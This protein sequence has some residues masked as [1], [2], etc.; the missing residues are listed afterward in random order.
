MSARRDANSAASGA[1]RISG[2]SQEAPLEDVSAQAARLHDGDPPA[3][4][5]HDPRPLERGEEPADAL[6]RCARELRQVRLRHANGD[7]LTAGRRALL[8]DELREDSGD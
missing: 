7:A 8:G 3:P 1:W 4:D 6:A 5:L 2:T